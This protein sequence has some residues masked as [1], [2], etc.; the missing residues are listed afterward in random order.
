MIKLESENIYLI[1]DTHGLRFIDLLKH[2]GIKDFILIHVGDA[3]EGFQHTASDRYDVDRLDKYCAENNGQILVV[4][5][6]HSDPAFYH[7]SHWSSSFSRI[8]FVPDYSYYTING[9]V[10]LF[11][12]GATSIDRV[13]RIENKS[14]WRGETFILPDDYPT[15]DNCDVLITHSSGSSEYPVDGLSRISGWF[16]NNPTLKEDLIAERNNIQKLYDHVNPSIGHWYGHFH[17]SSIEY[18]PTNGSIQ[19]CLDINEVV[20]I[21]KLLV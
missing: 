10:F 1:G 4:R 3:G 14:W 12:G 17:F 7:K 20:D 21:S 8:T 9:K 13:V 18:N 19:R 6:N 11:V 16:K 15:L 5:G 2:Y